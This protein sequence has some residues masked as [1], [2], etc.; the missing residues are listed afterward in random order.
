MQR[1]NVGNTNTTTPS[2]SAVANWTRRWRDYLRD[3]VSSFCLGCF[4]GALAGVICHLAFRDSRLAPRFHGLL[5]S[6]WLGSSF[7]GLVAYKLEL[8]IL[9]LV[10]LVAGALRL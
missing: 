8:T 3:S 5:A 4:F 6:L 2:D 9:A 10:L 1:S 7:D